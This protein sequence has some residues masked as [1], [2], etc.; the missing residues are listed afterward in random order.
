MPKKMIEFMKPAQFTIYTSEPANVM[1]T[2]KL[3]PDSG[4]DV[5]RLEG[6]VDSVLPGMDL[7][8]P[9]LVYADLVNTADARAIEAAHQLYEQHIQSRYQ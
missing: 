2:F 9:V 5:A 8:D 4:G 1:R 3:V 7:V 6:F